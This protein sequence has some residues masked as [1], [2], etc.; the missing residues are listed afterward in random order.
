MSEYHSNRR[1]ND[2]NFRL[3]GS[4]RSR[5]ISALKGN[6]KGDKTFKLIG[7]NIEEFR[8]RIEIQ[9][10]PEMSWSNWGEVWEIDHIKPCTAFDLTKEEE[11]RLCFHFSNQQPLFKTTKIAESFGYINEIGN[12][13]KSN[14]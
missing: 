13:N 12:R 10:K 6:F 11:Q 7:C 1:K 14:N 2:I 8:K 9:F 4:L 5:V 3:Q